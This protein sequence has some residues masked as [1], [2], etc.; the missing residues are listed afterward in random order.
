MGDCKCSIFSVD[1]LFSLKFSQVEDTIS[2]EI[3]VENMG[4]VNYM[5]MD[6]QRKGD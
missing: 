3:L 4:R 5:G 1:N 6:Q 2:L